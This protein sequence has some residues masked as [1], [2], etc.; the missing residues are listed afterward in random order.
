MKTRNE[1]NISTKKTV[2]LKQSV[3]AVPKL[4]SLQMTSE[5]ASPEIYKSKGKEKRLN[6]KKTSET[7]ITLRE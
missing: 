3:E 5:E 4:T 7:D 1:D 2:Y 6:N